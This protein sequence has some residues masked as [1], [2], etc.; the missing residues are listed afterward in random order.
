MAIAYL[1]L[2]IV[3][4]GNA[5][6]CRN[7]IG[8][9]AYDSREK[10]HSLDNNHT[11][12]YSWKAGDLENKAILLPK[13]APKEF[14]DRQT[15]WQAVEQVETSSKAQLARKILLALPKEITAEQRKELVE[16]Y[17]KIAFVNQGMCV[18]YAIHKPDKGNENY[19][20]H[21]MVTM[22]SIDG[23]GNWQNKKSKIYV[24]DNNGNK[25]PIIDKTT[26]KQK[27]G[28]K[29]R[30]M[31]K[32]KIIK[33]N[34]WDNP[35]N[36]EIW[37][38]LA[39]Q[40]INKYLSKDNQISMKSYERQG[41]NKLGQVHEGYSQNSEKKTIN[42]RIKKL[43]EIDRTLDKETEKWNL[44]K[45]KVENEQISEYEAENR[46]H[47]IAIERR[48]QGD[49]RDTTPTFKEQEEQYRQEVLK[50]D[51]EVKQ[52][53]EK[54]IKLQQQLDRDKARLQKMVTEAKIAGKEKWFFQNEKAVRIAYL[55][56]HGY[57]DLK[58]KIENEE[59]QLTEQQQQKQNLSNEQQRQQRQQYIFGA[60]GAMQKG[61]LTGFENWCREQQVSLAMREDITNPALKQ[62]DPESRDKVNAEIKEREKRFNEM[63]KTF[64]AK[65]E[66]QKVAP[67]LSAQEQ[68]KKKLQE[69]EQKQQQPKPK[70]KL[71]VKHRERDDDTGRSGQSR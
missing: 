19:H 63:V 54:E 65:A 30:L 34:D 32:T 28:D 15:L 62:L 59:K 23:H 18:D 13:N 67:E 43:N 49:V 41:I 35:K 16:N 31:F 2:K 45:S 46:S 66:K 70:A 6:Q 64:N 3:S 27:I 48:E 39:E 21:I 1:Q 68:L 20:A 11:Y 10:L 4:R 24:L 52:L 8:S 14:Q 33:T 42:L 50:L 56:E 53:T 38:N 51:K 29:G 55:K 9:S 7:C 61:G 5:R 26:G 44:F 22:R 69:I 12:N 37:R 47:K 40:E 57:L 36:L 58:Q 71:I 25:I 17:C 60:A